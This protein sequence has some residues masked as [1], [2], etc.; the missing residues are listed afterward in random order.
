MGK[1]FVLGL[2]RSRTYWMSVFLNCQHEAKHYY[3]NYQEFMLNDSPGDSTTCYPWIKEHITD[4]RVVVIN[5]DINEC[6]ESSKELFPS[7][8]IDVLEYIQDELDSIENCLRIK[9][10]DISDRLEE[11]WDFCYK[12][13]MPFDKKWADSIKKIEIENRSL[14]EV[15]KRQ[16]EEMHAKHA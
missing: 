9:Y 3:P 6:F 7:A 14:I 5:R 12:Q 4:H 16:L 8:T 13:E 2:P 1:F 10:E 11:I 15:T